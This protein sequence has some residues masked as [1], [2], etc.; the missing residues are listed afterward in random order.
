MKEAKEDLLYP[1]VPL[2]NQWKW[3]DYF[4][5]LNNSLPMG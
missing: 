4:F 3:Q 1:N 2:G 5:K